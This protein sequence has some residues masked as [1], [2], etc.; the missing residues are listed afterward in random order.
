MTGLRRS[1]RQPKAAAPHAVRPAVNASTTAAPAAKGNRPSAAS[2]ADRISSL[3]PEIVTMVLGNI[4]AQD[5]RTM[6]A[7]GRTNKAFYTLM[8]PRLYGRVVLHAQYHIHIAKLIRTLEPLL[9]ITQKKQL[10]KEGTYKGQQENGYRPGPDEDAKPICADHVRQLIVGWVDPGRN[11]KFIVLRYLEEAV[12]TLQNLEIINTWVMNAS[13]AR[14]I[15][16][17]KHLQA[18]SIRSRDLG[19]DDA[20]T[21]ALC[22]VKNLRHLALVTSDWSDAANSS[23][24]E[25]LVRNSAS[26]LKSLYLSTASYGIRFLPYRNGPGL[27]SSGTAGYRLTNLTSLRL[28]DFHLDGE[29]AAEMLKSVD[30]V[31]LD[32]LALGR[33]RSESGESCG[34]LFDPLS[35]AFAAASQT[36]S[37]PKLRWLLIG[38]SKGVEARTRFVGSFSTLTTLLAENH[39]KYKESVSTNPGLSSALLAGILGHRNL[40]TLELAHPRGCQ[41]GE[42]VPHLSAQTVRALVDGLPELRE[43]VLAPVEDQIDEIAR[44][45]VEAK[46]LTSVTS[47]IYDR[48]DDK[49][50]FRTVGAIVRAFLDHVD[51]TSQQMGQGFVW[52]DHYRLRRVSASY[53]TWAVASTFPKQRKGD[54]VT[55]ERVTGR[56]HPDRGVLVKDATESGSRLTVAGFDPTFG[57]VDGVARD[58]A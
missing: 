1:S 15:A 35:A 47:T 4:D 42:R 51:A 41:T 29:N 19:R 43:L 48:A 26:T 55:P 5:H 54:K 57:W 3:P 17:Q 20:T 28:V 30:F 46:N 45:L 37:P 52:E 7:L 44:V 2:S 25:C 58:L 22:R 24:E 16:S 53:R 12:R 11:H 6:N 34:S 50:G 38:L 9:T 56:A 36:A 18:L 14:G 31:R 40:R 33:N 10:M 27:A 21:E 32:E 13:I 23:V 8:M 39:G 49:P